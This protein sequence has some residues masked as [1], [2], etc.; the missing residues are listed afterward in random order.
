MKLQDGRITI[1]VSKEET[2]IEI[3]DSKSAITFCKIILTAEQFCQALSRLS[4]T[5][6]EV[7]VFALDK[8]GK[9][10]ENKNFKFEIP[11]NLRSYSKVK[12][13]TELCVK[14]LKECN[15]SE[16][17]PDE[18]FGSQDTFSNENGKTYAKAVIR[19]WI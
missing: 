14:A 16:W 8:I 9:T 17:R 10:H 18:Y 6:C 2:I 11:E 5:K 13:L 1:L 4:Q 7:N 19:R 15:M 3:R 12:E